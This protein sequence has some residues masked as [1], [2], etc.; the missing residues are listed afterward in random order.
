MVAFSLE[1]VGEAVDRQVAEIG[2]MGKKEGAIDTTVL[3]G[4]EDRTFWMRVR[5]FALATKAPVILKS[6]FV[7]SKQTEILGT[8]EKMAQAAGV[9]CAFIG[10]AGNGILRTYVLQSD[11]GKTEP[12]V[13]LIGKF[14]A[15]AV[16]QDGNLVVESCPSELK[17]KISVWG[18]SRTDVVMMRRLKEKM[19]PFGVLNPGRFV[20]SI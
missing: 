20:G 7:I 13:D 19:D 10:H 14:T 1:G 9:G 15:E 3:K 2:E 12:L 18:Q 16:K 4:H 5:D 8:Y 17:A 11:A 6:N